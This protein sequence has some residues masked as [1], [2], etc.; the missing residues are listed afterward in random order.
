M[1]VVSQLADP[2]IIASFL[3]TQRIIFFAQVPIYAQLPRIFQMMSLH[4]FSK[5]KL[6]IS[7]SIFIG[8]SILIVLLVGI[9]ILGNVVLTKLVTTDIFLIMAIILEYHHSVHS[10]IY[11]GSNHVPALF[12]GVL[13]I[14]IGIGVVGTYGLNGIVLTQFFV[15]L[16]I[17]NWYPVYLNLKL[18]DWKFVDYLKNVIMIPSTYFKRN[19]H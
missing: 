14:I 7:K 17:N 12:S 13:I 10:Q 15:Q 4:Q 2:K 8:F 9:G 6:F 1:E 19:I 3:V 5:L 11:M 18:L 16:S